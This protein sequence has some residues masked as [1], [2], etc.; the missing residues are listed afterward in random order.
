MEG[1]GKAM[2]NNETEDEQFRERKG[3]GLVVD[4]DGER[5]EIEGMVVRIVGIKGKLG[6]GGRDEAMVTVLFLTKAITPEDDKL[7]DG[8]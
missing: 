2:V 6:S 7:L 5:K 4:G 3:V 1:A 8:H